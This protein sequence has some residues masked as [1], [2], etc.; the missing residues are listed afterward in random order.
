MG[1]AKGWGDALAIIDARK[2]EVH[3]QTL[4]QRHKFHADETARWQQAQQQHQAQVAARQP[5]TM[6]EQAASVVRAGV[7]Y[8]GGQQRK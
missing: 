5:P 3:T 8:V 1:T 6:M 4:A 2:D 7:K